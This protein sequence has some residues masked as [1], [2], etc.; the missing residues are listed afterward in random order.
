MTKTEKRMELLSAALTHLE[1][2]AKLL[3][4]AEEEVLAEEAGELADKV[5]V[6]AIAEAAWPQ[7]APPRGDHEQPPPPIGHMTHETAWEEV[8]VAG[9]AAPEARRPMVSQSLRRSRRRRG[10]APGKL[11][12]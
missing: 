7:C 4:E 3:Q 2:V 8:G 12:A 6:V 1:T 9:S 10:A 5:D 11:A